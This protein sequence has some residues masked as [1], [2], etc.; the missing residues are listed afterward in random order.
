M[1]RWL[2][3]M[4]LF[5]LLGFA[6]GCATQQSAT[7][8]GSDG[9]NTPAEKS[10]L[11]LFDERSR[12]DFL[13]VYDEYSAL[14]DSVHTRAYFLNQN[15]RRILQDHAPHFVSTNLATGFPT[16]P[17]LNQPPFSRTN[18]IQKLFAIM[19]VNEPSFTIYQGD[20]NLGSHQLPVYQDRKG[21]YEED[22]K[23]DATAVVKATTDTAVYVGTNGG[24]MA[25]MCLWALAQSGY[26]F[27]V[28]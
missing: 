8:A 12:G 3:A 7:N 22:A 25:L 10:N 11:R 23:E 21:V 1:R 15:E 5:L 4:L 9:W 24:Y 18:Q 17:V 19:A 26:A 16:I 27:T 2:Q 14:H 20:R 6:G 28:H 13:V